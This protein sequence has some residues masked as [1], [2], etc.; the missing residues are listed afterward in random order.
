MR[1]AKL[2]NNYPFYAPNPIR[3]GDSYIGN[4]PDSVYAEQGYLPVVETP[5]P[6]TDERHYTEPHWAEENG[7]IVQT[8]EV[9]E[10]PVSDEATAEDYEAAL[11]EVGVSFDEE[12]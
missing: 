3:I 12:D 11:R 8:W 10:I 1:Y 5:M 6:E 2:I 7:Q 4:P 9:V